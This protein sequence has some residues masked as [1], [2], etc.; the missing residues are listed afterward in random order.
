MSPSGGRPLVARVIAR[1]NV[2]GPAIHVMNLTHGLAA[3]YPTLLITGTVG[4]DEG[5]MLPDA[6]ARGLPL[7]VIPEL[8]RSVRPW[9]DVVAL[10][11]LTVLFR[12]IRPALVHTHTAKAGTLG[13][14]AAI[15]ARVP[16][17]VHTFHGHVFRGYFGRLTPLVI[18]VERTLARLTTRIITVSE[19]QADELA[20]EFRIAPR[21]RIAVIPLG[22]DLSRF[23][24][25]AIAPLRGE[26]RREI[27][28]GDAPIVTIVGRLV[29]IKN[30]ELF[31]RA[32]AEVV[33]RG[34]E[35]LFVIVGGG[36]EGPRLRALATELGIDRQVRFLGWRSD[37]PRIYADS[38]VVALTSDNEGTPVSLIE[39]LAA[40]CAVASTDVGGVRDVL[41]GGRL[42]ALTPAGDASAMAA[43]IA[44]LLDDPSSSKAMAL[45]GSEAVATRYGVDRLVSDMAS[46]YDSLLSRRSDAPGAAASPHQAR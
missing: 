5:D 14:V 45:R 20:R 26:L 18:A 42:G 19:S 9:H 23:V 38:D 30:H 43:A 11:R 25:A 28:A 13:R 21:E 22:L 31:L 41:D 27:Q 12:R 3:E 46:L 1:L 6:V 16:V 17:R 40:G 24:P 7:H 35:C 39:A 37:L 44:S 29:P 34:R 10:Y 32:A 33:A 4:P 8:G 15:V 36:D 2:G